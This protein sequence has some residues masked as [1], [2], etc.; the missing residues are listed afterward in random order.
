MMSFDPAIPYTGAA[1]ALVDVL[2]VNCLVFT[3]NLPLPNRLAASFWPLV[4]ALLAVT[5]PLLFPGA[6]A[7]K[8]YRCCIAGAFLLSWWTWRMWRLRQEI[9]GLPAVATADRVSKQD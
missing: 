6:E 4:C 7:I 1:A 5:T 2:L 9:C 8:V 3:R